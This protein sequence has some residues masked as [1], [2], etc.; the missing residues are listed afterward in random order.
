MTSTWRSVKKSWSL[1]LCLL[2]FLAVFFTFS[3]LPVLRS[4]YYSFTYNNI[5][6]PPVFNGLANYK[7]L[8]LHDD[9][10]VKACINTV[11]F[12]AITGVVGYMASLL[13]AW[14]IN[15]FG[16]V[17]RTVLV[18]VFYMPS[19]SGQL[20]MVW[21][22]IF[23][24]D[25]LGY[26]NSFLTRMG[27]L[28]EPVQWLTDPKYMMGVIIAA[29]LWMSLAA[30]FLAFIAGLQGVDRELYEAGSLD[31]IRNRFQE[32][33]FITLPAIRPQLM[34]G[35][36]MSITSSFA[37]S[38]IMMNLAGFPSTDYAAHTLVTHLQDY[39]F[40][41]FDMGYACAIATVLFVVMVTVNKLVQR[42]L[43]GVGQV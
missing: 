39:G 36:V 20:Y 12:A 21:M 32:L 10:F 42:L 22:L 5:V 3:V 13:L 17:L 15:D 26:A 2:P 18:I 6:S 41:R 25:S 4:V 30:G 38:D 1:Y 8:F 24:G 35:A 11:V 7:N 34:F 33:W 43:K 40:L 37:A 27:F 9:V 23:S 19:I 31:G 14:L 16:R 29:A 28:R